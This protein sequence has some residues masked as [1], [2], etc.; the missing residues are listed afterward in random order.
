[1]TLPVSH[2]I[3]DVWSMGSNNPYSIPYYIGFCGSTG[4]TSGNSWEYFVDPM[5]SEEVT[6]QECLDAYALYVLA[7]VP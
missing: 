6:C 1:M 7:E 5:D 4:Y 2:L 3:S